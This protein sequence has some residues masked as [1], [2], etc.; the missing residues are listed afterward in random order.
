MFLNKWHLKIL[1]L[2]SEPGSVYWR[3]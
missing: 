2:P 3:L 1:S